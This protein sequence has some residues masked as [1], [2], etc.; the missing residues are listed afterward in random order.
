M[1]KADRQEQRDRRNKDAETDTQGSATRE[2][3]SNCEESRSGEDI[4]EHNQ[5]S[6]DQSTPISR[7]ADPARAEEIRRALAAVKSSS[8][9]S[10]YL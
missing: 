9:L 6:S 3:G 10:R 5:N 7:E 2:H 8:S 4:G 1:E